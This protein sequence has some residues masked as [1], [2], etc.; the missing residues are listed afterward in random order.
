MVSIS[1]QL[2]PPLT[3]PPPS[4]SFAAATARQPHSGYSASSGFGLSS[5]QLHRLIKHRLT[6]N[7]CHIDFESRQMNGLVAVA[8]FYSLSD[9][10]AS[11]DL[12][13]TQYYLVM[14]NMNQHMLKEDHSPTC[15][16]KYVVPTDIDL[17]Q[18]W[19]NF[20]SL[21]TSS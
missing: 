1:T 5:L 4:Q 19:S 12:C 14:I 9:W 7:R 11:G 3:L 10:F 17:G 13:G 8:P 15:S 16:W 18:N 20:S 6:R 21:S 2:L